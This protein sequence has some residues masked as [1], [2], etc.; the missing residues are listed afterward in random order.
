ML[1][2][3]AVH[4]YRADFKPEHAASLIRDL[5]EDLSEFALSDVEMAIRVYRMDPKSKFFP[6]SGQLR[7]LAMQARQDHTEAKRGPI[8]P[9]LGESRP[10]MWWTKPKK[11][12]KDHWREDEISFDYRETYR[13]RKA[14]GLT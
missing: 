14:K 11:L 10:L 9:V 3:L 13:L 5:L 12:W 2:R 6:T 4:Y 1:S 8:K 7:A